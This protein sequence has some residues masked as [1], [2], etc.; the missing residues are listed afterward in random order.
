MKALTVSNIIAGFRRT[1]TWP[2]NPDVLMEDM[3]PNNTFDINDGEDVSTVRNMLSLLSV[4]VS[5]EV[6]A[7]NIAEIHQSKLT[8]IGQP[9][10]LLKA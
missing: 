6:V 5:I 3:Q 4:D 10:T 9:T 2:L 1:W 8:V 7:K